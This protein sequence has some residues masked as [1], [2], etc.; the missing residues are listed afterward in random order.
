MLRRFEGSGCSGEAPVGRWKHILKFQ[1]GIKSQISGDS[2]WN[3]CQCSGGCWALLKA[4]SQCKVNIVS[5]IYSR[6][7]FW[8]CTQIHLKLKSAIIR[9]HETLAFS[10]EIFALMPPLDEVHLYIFLFFINFQITDHKWDK[11]LGS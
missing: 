10:S 2:E 3:T 1:S 8:I 6:Y 9:L 5:V 7:K 11:Y 4:L